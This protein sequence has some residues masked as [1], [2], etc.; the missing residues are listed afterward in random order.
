MNDGNV[1][2]EGLQGASIMQEG[3][4]ATLRQAQA[5]S[6][7]GF[8]FSAQPH[9]VIVAGFL[10]VFMPSSLFQS[11]WPK[12]PYLCMS[13]MCV[14]RCDSQEPALS[15]VPASYSELLEGRRPCAW[16]WVTRRKKSCSCPKEGT[17][18]LIH[19][20]KARDATI[21]LSFPSS[22]EPGDSL[23]PFMTS[24]LCFRTPAMKTV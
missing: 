3:T 20:G 8:S 4:S 19:G 21:L 15:P 12:D 7:S 17:V 1:G 16:H 22:C 11:F 10:N 9:F 6:T 24:N 14:S 5:L 23:S 18:V 13:T 2:E